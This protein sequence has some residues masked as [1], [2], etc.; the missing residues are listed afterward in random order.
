MYNAP[1]SE[2]ELMYFFKIITAGE[3]GV[4]KTTLLY[5]FVDGVFLKDTKM[6]IGVEFFLKEVNIGVIN[7]KLQLWDLGGQEQFRS[8]L[9][10][11][12]SGANAA[13]LMFDLTRKITLI[14]LEEWIKILRDDNPNLP[15]ILLA[16][17]LDLVDLISVTDEDAHSYMK[18][19]DFIDYLKVSSKTGHNVNES[20]DILAKHIIAQVQEQEKQE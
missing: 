8:L 12:I 9:R 20:F 15:I 11:Y 19:Y 10:H 5:R 3:G 13:I 16:S 1:K 14:K 18:E 6:T 4:G 2:D 17:K 7:C